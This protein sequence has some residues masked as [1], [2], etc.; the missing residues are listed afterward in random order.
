[1]EE[2]ERDRIG[3]N[4][5]EKERNGQSPIGNMWS[6]V[7]VLYC[8]TAGEVERKHGSAAVLEGTNICRRRLT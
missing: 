5:N 6:A 3:E 2:N 8:L 7:S 1:M 4:H